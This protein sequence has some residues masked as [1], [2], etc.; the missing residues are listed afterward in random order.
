MKTL[1]LLCA[2]AFF[3][4]GCDGDSVYRKSTLP[5]WEYKVAEHSENNHECCFAK[6]ESVGEPVQDQEI[7]RYRLFMTIYKEPAVTA[8]EKSYSV[9]FAVDGS[10]LDLPDERSVIRVRFD[11]GAESTYFLEKHS[12]RFLYL[13]RD[14]QQMDTFI[15]EVERSEKMVVSF[16]VALIGKRSFEFRTK[17]LKLNRIS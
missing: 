14:Q 5:S 17:G 15:R 3:V 13:S 10:D 2:V 1:L 11:D 6:I 4:G 9:I 8:G 16:D 7:G 12:S